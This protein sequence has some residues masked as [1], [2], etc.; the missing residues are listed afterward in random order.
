MRHGEHFDE[1][2]CIPHRPSALRP[3]L[4]CVEV[5]LRA[6]RQSDLL[7]HDGQRARSGIFL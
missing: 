4:R 5:V 3:W 6:T 1:T 7:A 2:V